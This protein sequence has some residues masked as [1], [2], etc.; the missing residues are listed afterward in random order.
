MGRTENLIDPPVTE[1]DAT[2]LYVFFE[3][4]LAKDVGDRLSFLKCATLLRRTDLREYVHTFALM[5]KRISSLIPEP[6]QRDL[7]L[8]YP[9]TIQR[10][11]ELLWENQEA[12]GEEGNTIMSILSDQAVD[13]LDQTEMFRVDLDTLLGD[14]PSLLPDDAAALDDAILAG[15]GNFLYLLVALADH[16]FVSLLPYDTEEPT[17]AILK[18]RSFL[19]QQFGERFDD[20]IIEFFVIGAAT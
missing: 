5:K 4:L 1:N 10:V 7:L 18:T 2:L 9:S 19:K 14:C 16:V 11:H 3:E 13:Y 20:Q 12:Y 8:S 17:E 15:K 6:R